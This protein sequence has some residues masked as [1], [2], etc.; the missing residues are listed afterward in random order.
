MGNPGL[1]KRMIE[2]TTWEEANELVNEGAR[3]IEENPDA[4][5]VLSAGEFLA[6]WISSWED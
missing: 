3:W 1:A 2:F 5:A 4:D 6:M